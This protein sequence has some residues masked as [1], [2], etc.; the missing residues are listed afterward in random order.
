MSFVTQ[1]SIPEVVEKAI[2]SSLDDRTSILDSIQDLG[3]PDM[4]HLKKHNSTSNTK[5]PD[6]G[7]YFY[8][9]G[10]DV[11]SSAAI[12]ALLNSISN[13][14]GESPQ[15]WFGK[16]KPWKVKEATYCT[17]NA[18]S[19]MDIR[20]TVNFPGGVEYIIIDCDGNQVMEKEQYWI[21]TYI[22]SVVRSLITADGD[23]SADFMSIVEI[24]KINPFLSVDQTKLFFKGFESLFFDGIKLGCNEELQVPTVSNNY[25]IDAFKI[26]VKLTGLYDEAIEL[27]KRLREIEPSI[28]YLIAELY[29]LH[30]E[31]I[32]SIEIIHD[33]II[34]DPLDGQLLMVQAQYCL[35]K[36]RLDLALPIAIRA[37]NASPS[38]FKPWALLVEVYISLGK[39]EEA[40]LTLNSCPMVTHKDKYHL[41]RIN[42]P[43]HEDLHLPL[44]VDVTLDQV[45]TL[46][47]M[48][49]AVE[50]QQIDQSLLNLPAANLKS[51]FAHAYKLLTEIV[52]RT[53][54]ETLLKYRTKVFVMEEEFRKDNN[55]NNSSYKNA[56][57]NPNSNLSLDKSKETSNGTTATNGDVVNGSS[58]N[59]S[60]IVNSATEEAKVEDGPIEV[61]PP[62]AKIPEAAAHSNEQHLQSSSVKENSKSEETSSLKS[63][64]S[65][66]FK[67]KRLCERWLDNLFMLLYEDL[68]I[69]TMY[70]AEIM[71]FEAQQLDIKKTTL[72]WE[73]LGLVAHRLGH[74]REA[75]QTF[76]KALTGRFAVRSSKKLL[77]FYIQEKVRLRKIELDNKHHPSMSP[78]EAGKESEKLNDLVTELIVKLTVW[79]HR[80][81]CGFSP[82][83]IESLAAIVE[84]TGR[85]KVESEIKAFF[86]GD[87]NG[88]F[89]LMED[90]LGFLET[91]KLIESD[92]LKR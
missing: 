35:D 89:T 21:E 29:L 16:N 66:D 36:K 22:S 69:Y 83:L 61:P 7:T 46:N 33:G 68:R 49:V 48:D 58:E 39:F 10:A 64:L 54:W 5:Q 82:F 50:H 78:E 43:Q 2:G 87:G 62:P 4:I 20:V 51:T 79:N 32:K 9:T 74:K 23:T 17:Y 63:K 52:H 28:T 72:E 75:A 55:N 85:V 18:F 11:S 3:P 47:S 15:L 30:D 26:A 71:H 76:R 86:D 27:L 1:G 24:R 81:Y 31:E 65:P 6:I 14:I 38:D 84:E 60:T 8:Y 80:W 44:P 91:F 53:G 34:Q 90:S 70:R 25:L 41:K 40:L 73:L 13:I 67:K 45:S 56:S 37:V 12:A 77:E 57:V 92:K 19:K 88:V 42:N 59:S